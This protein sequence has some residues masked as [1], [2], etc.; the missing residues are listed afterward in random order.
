[1]GR[2]AEEGRKGGTE[3]VLSIGCLELCL[4]VLQEGMCVPVVVV[5]RGRCG[6]CGDW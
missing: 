4:Q 6:D 5:C 2:L 1:M 3:R